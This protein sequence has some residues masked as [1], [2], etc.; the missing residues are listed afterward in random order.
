MTQAEAAE[1][2]IAKGHIIPV[3]DGVRVRREPAA[4]EDPQVL[5]LWQRINNS[6]IKEKFRQA[7]EDSSIS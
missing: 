4:D 6:R 2:L 5:E 7:M 3:S 1:V